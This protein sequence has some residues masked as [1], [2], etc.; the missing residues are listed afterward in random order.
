MNSLIN[1]KFITYL[2]P[3]S[4]VIN[5]ISIDFLLGFNDRNL[6]KALSLIILIF[7]F[8]LSGKINKKYFYFI[9][10]SFFFYFSLFFSEFI[11]NSQGAFIPLARLLASVMFLWVIFSCDEYSLS[12]IL[13]IYSRVLLFVAVL[14]LFFLIYPPYIAEKIPV[15]N[16]ISTKSIIFE[17]NV[18]GIS[19]YFLFL[20]YLSEGNRNLNKSV[21][22]FLAIFSSFYRTVIALSLLRIFLTK[23]II[24]ISVLLLLLISFFSD[25]LLMVFKFEQLSS[26]TGRDVLWSIGLTGFSE[27]PI[28]GKGEGQI[29]FYS[30]LILNRDPAFTTFH[31]VFVDIFF[32]GGVFAFIFYITL[33]F[34]VF[35]KLKYKDWLLFSLFLAPS[36]LNT[37]FLFSFNVLSG[38]LSVWVVYKI[39]LAEK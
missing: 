10:I 33:L 30:N 18:Y 39:K 20:Y 5:A 16:L 23:L 29:P 32:S 25:E 9:S 19:M 1:K 17:Q 11:F 28:F 22:S 3:I 31:N 4:L 26:L 8:S 14:G 12:K 7:V 6:F 2:L 13:N 21:L 15:I 37:Y 27:S 36:L 38:F 24:P 35:L 34:L